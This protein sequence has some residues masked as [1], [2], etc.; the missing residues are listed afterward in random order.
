HPI[1]FNIFPHIGGLSQEFP[2]YFAEEVKMIK[3]TRKILNKPDLP[4]SATCVR[5]PV[6]NG[7]CESL[8]VELKKPANPEEARAI[9]SRMPGA[10]I[11]DDPE[12]N[13]YPLPTAAS[14]KDEVLVGRIRANPI[15]QFGL[16]LWIAADNIRKGAALNAVQIAEEMLAQGLL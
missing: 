5:V 3:E 16:D 15:F 14:G 1:A 8:T 10:K 2:G 11:V 6:F 12:R 13:E 4:I 9:L 7:H